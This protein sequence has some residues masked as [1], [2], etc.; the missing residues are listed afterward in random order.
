MSSWRNLMTPPQEKYYI[1]EG[2]PS[3]EDS[4]CQEKFHHEVSDFTEEVP[5]RQPVIQS[6]KF[7]E[8]HNQLNQL[9]DDL[10]RSTIQAKDLKGSVMR[11]QVSPFEKSDFFEST[12][13]PTL[14]TKRKGI[15]RGTQE[16]E[17]YSAS[18]CSG[19]SRKFL[20]KEVEVRAFDQSGGIDFN[21]VYVKRVL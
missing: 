3:L 7:K 20:S 8:L 17:L 1:N 15:L 19:F 9:K 11:K 21:F 5:R 13:R 14:Q 16:Q 10:G 6:Q 2:S 18:T 4:Y 12:P